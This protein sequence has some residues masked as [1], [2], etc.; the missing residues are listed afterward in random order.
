MPFSGRIVASGAHLH[1]S[2]KGV[3]ISEPGCGDRTIIRHDPLYG[4]RT[5]RLQIRPI[6]HEPGPIATGYFLS[7]QGIP[8]RRQKLDVTGLYDDENR[9][10][11]RWRSRT[12]TSRRTRR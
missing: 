11:R 1:G 3:E 4:C 6:L 5:T 7:K 10:R 8:V 9:T 2:S 12:S